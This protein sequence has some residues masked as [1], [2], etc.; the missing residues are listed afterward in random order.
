[1]TN[2]PEGV[3]GEV[4]TGVGTLRATIVPGNQRNQIGTVRFSGL[5]LSSEDVLRELE[6]ALDGCNIDL[7]PAK[8]EDFFIKNSQG[9]TGVFPGEFHTA[10]TLAFM[11]VRLS[12]SVAP[13]P[14]D[15]KKGK[16]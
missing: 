10:L 12:S 8:I 1:M 9:L 11:K 13:D 16:M 3:I 5:Q 6:A 14:S 7:A 4:D 2:Q 15:W